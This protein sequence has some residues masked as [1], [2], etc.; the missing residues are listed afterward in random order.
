MTVTPFKTETSSRGARVL[1][2]ALG[3]RIT[4]WLEDAGV[5]EVVTTLTGGSGLTG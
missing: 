1:R 2:T 4:A 3:P 5:V